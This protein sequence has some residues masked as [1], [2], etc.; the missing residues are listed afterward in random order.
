MRIY[1][2]LFLVAVFIVAAVCK[3]YTFQTSNVDSPFGFHT[4]FYRP[5]HKTGENPKLEEMFDRNNP[6][7][8]YQDAQY[9]G[10]KW[11]RIGAPSPQLPPYNWQMTDMTYYSVPPG[12]NILTNIWVRETPFIKPGTWQFIDKRAEDAYVKFVE[13]LVDRYDGDGIND[14]PGLKNPIKYWQIE[15]EPFMNNLSAGSKINLDWRGFARLVKV[16][17]KAI[18]TSDPQAKVLIGGTVGCEL[19]Y[20][21]SNLFRLQLE[22]LYLPVLKSLQGRYIDIFDM[23]YYGSCGASQD[24]WA[25]SKQAFTMYRKILNENGYGN[26]PVWFAES[27]CPAS[28]GHEQSQ[29]AEIIKRHIFPLSYGVKKIFWAWGLMEGYP[30]MTGTDYFD[31]TGLV[32]DGIGQG[33]PGYGVKKLSYYAYKKMTE[34]TDG[35]NWNYVRTVQE[36]DRVYIYQL[37]KDGKPFWVAWNDN[38]GQAQITL[39][40]I[41]AKRLKVTEAVPRFSSGKEVIDYNSAFNVETKD[42]VKEKSVI[43]LKSRPVYIEML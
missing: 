25:G 37:V 6:H 36:K 39:S 2:I 33:D 41:G 22:E 1:V 13:S 8:R 21:D 7:K 19:L 24:A 29:A 15:N 32:Y 18:K 34:I 43:T 26:T 27:G 35:C 5:Y 11:E 10:V 31:H 28:P 12:I 9:I 23:H 14:M 30:P 4:A 16:T 42:V 20:T 17:Y 38:P 40:G 3:G